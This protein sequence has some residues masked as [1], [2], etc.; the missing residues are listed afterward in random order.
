MAVKDGS[1]GAEE[2]RKVE[3]SLTAS[4]NGMRLRESRRA[5]KGM[6]KH[7]QGLRGPR[8]SEPLLIYIQTHTHHAHHHASAGVSTAV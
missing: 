6:S 1:S 8:T 4:L 3:A 2:P 7:I 5:R